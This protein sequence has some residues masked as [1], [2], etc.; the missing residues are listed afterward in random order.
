[1][2]SFDIAL[3]WVLDSEDP[4]RQYKQ[5]PDAPPGAFA[6]SGI[7]SVAYPKQFDYVAS[8]PQAQR[9]LDVANFYRAEFWNEWY[10]QLTDDELAKRV[11]D[12]AVN[13]GPA[14]AVKLLQRAL[15]IKDDGLW[16]PNTVHEANS[17][18]N[19]VAMFTAARVERYQRIAAANPANAHYLPQWLARASR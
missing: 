2:A 7:N 17:E 13:G 9:G 16:G 6:I 5:V 1:M 14:T 10:S 19:I 11:L 18:P 3:N 15:A 4:Q 8:I 12:M